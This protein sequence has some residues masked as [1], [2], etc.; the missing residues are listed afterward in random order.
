MDAVTHYSSQRVM[1]KQLHIYYN[2]HVQGVGFRFT[3]R[4]LANE[5]GILGW[6]K[7]LSDGRV[8]IVAEQEEDVLQDFLLKISSRFAR[9]IE[10]VSVETLPAKGDFNDFD[11]KF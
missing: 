2:G 3:A 4:Y 5:L 9:Y 8:E 1:K 6:V 7:N 10:D 11:I